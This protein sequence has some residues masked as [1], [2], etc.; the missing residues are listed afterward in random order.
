MSNPTYHITMKSL[1]GSSLTPDD[2]PRIWLSNRNEYIHSAGK[3]KLEASGDTDT[4]ILGARTPLYLP[5][6]SLRPGFHIEADIGLIIRRFIK[7]SVM[8]DLLFNLDPV[9]IISPPRDILAKFLTSSG[10]R[11]DFPIPT[12]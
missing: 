2:M 3:R 1:N 8:R 9:S 10:V 4:E 11:S 12:E 5:G 6:W 7:S